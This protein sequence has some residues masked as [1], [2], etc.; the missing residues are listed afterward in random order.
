MVD[1]L[2]PEGPSRVALP[3]IKMIQA[4]TKM[5]W[6]TP[7]SIFPT[8]KGIEQKYFAPS[9]GPEYLF[10][11]PQLGLLVVASA[12]DKERQGQQAPTPKS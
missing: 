3:L 4:T 5:L 11:H 2:T 10:T 9:T 7:S 8:A 12:N 6:Q 1:I